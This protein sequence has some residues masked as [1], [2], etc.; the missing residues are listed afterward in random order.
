MRLIRF[1]AFIGMTHPAIAQSLVIRDATDKSPLE[2]VSV[3]SPDKE[4]ILYSDSKGRVDIRQ[5][6]GADSIVIHFL[7]YEEVFTNYSALDS[8]DFNMF[9]KAD[10][11]AMEE[12]VISASRWQQ[13]ASNITQK[14][15]QIPV[16]TVEMQNPQTTA[17]LVGLSGDVFIQKSQQG[18]GSPMIRGFSANRVLIAVD[19]VRMN[20][21]IFRSG[22]LQNVISIDPNA[23]EKAEVIFGPGS[24]LFGSDALGGVMNFRTLSPLYSNSDTSSFTD[25][26]TLLRYASASGEFTGHLDFRIASRK[27]A[28]VTSFSFSGFGDLR[29]GSRGPEEYLRK[30]YVLPGFSKDRLQSNAEPEVQVG[31]AYNQV[32]LLQKLAYRLSENTELTYAFSY[33]TSNDIPRYDRLIQRGSND[34]LRFARWHYGPQQWF[35]NSLSLDLRKK[36]ALYDQFRIILAHQAFEESREVRRFNE[37]IGQSNLEN[38]QAYSLNLDLRKKLSPNTELFYGAEGV[39]NQV[40][41]EAE[42]FGD[43]SAFALLPAALTRYPD[44]SDWLSAGAYINVQ[45]KFHRR[46]SAQAGLRYNQVIANAPFDTA[47]F[48]VL[49]ENARV[50]TNAV[51]GS[52][53][54]NYEP[55]EGLNI[56]TNF[57]TGF[58]AP[59]IDDIAK[60]FDSEPGA[61]VVPNPDLKSEY[62]NS[63]DLGVRKNF[64]DYI[65]F[66]ANAFY[67][68]LQNAMVRRDFTFNGQ[69]SIDY[70]GELS[71]VQAIVNAAESRIYGVQMAL[72]LNITSFFTIELKYNFQDGEEELDDGSKSAVRHVAPQ[73][74]TIQLKYR[75]AK[76]DAVAYAIYNGE[77]SYN[78]LAV[79]ERGKAHIYAK[80]ELG[81]PYSPQWYTLNLK[82]GYRVSDKTTLR[83]GVENILDERYRPYSSGIAAPGRN[84]IGSVKITL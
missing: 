48:P 64:E 70:Q 9:L 33:A 71:R 12:V 83:F 41:S 11:I 32:N 81:R 7:G 66:R 58:R 43:D 5:M 30:D 72:D 50:N 84:F 76:F 79:S 4:K 19:G 55:M 63:F 46:L 31:S 20:N 37:A 60:V 73:F 47:L 44:G 39:F 80:D 40:G 17:D 22:N 53:G 3:F 38:V 10:H 78:N 26:S 74:G 18:G 27:L 36:T 51:T 2:Y 67:T 82:L 77:I 49:V 56:T 25:A 68:I 35:M 8:L 52:A 21:A 14:V 62:A 45:T 29:M 28:S 1:I 75:N 61:V 57:S 6:R 13:D 65:I 15:S 42:Y 34:S 69:D 16:R 23:V 59:N 24:T 54:L